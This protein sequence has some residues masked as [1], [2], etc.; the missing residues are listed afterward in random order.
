M[1]NSFYD[2]LYILVKNRRTIIWITAGF[3]VFALVLSLLIPKKYKATATL[4]PPASQSMSL[5]SLAFKAGMPSD[6][7]VGGVGFMPGMVTPSDVFAFMLKNGAVTGRVID[8]CGLVKHYKKDKQLAKDPGKALYNVNKKLDKV[9]AIKVTDERF[10]TVTVEDKSPDKAAEIANCYGDVL[11][12]IYSQLNMSQGQRARE[13]I[14][15]RVAQEEVLLREMEDSLRVFQKRFRTVSITEEMK[16]LIEMSAKIE[17]DIMTK[18]IE[19]E[20]LKSYNTKDNSQIKI[21]TTEIDKAEQQLNNLMVGGKD[22]TLFIPFAKAPDIGTELTRRMRAV[23]I[24]QEVYALLVEQLEHAKI[25]EAKDTPKIQFL[26]RA[27]PPWKKSWP[28]RLLIIIFGMLIGFIVSAGSMV[29]LSWLLA[30]RKDDKYKNLIN[31]FQ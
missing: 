23:R 16:A 28:K 15:N 31:L 21:L 17:A 18:R 29:W 24:H 1:I 11:N 19:L 12:S 6:P 20:A 5:M 2:L 3:T 7:E 27:S 22:K 30:I 13:F 26:E 8:Q 25:L 14:E 10:I 4:M 9:T